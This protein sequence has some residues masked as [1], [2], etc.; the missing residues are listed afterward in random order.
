MQ[1]EATVSGRPLDLQLVQKLIL[2]GL[3]LQSLADNG[4]A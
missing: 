4:L 3:L 1:K 2:D